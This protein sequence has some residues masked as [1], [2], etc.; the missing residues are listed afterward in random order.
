MNQTKY[1]DIVIIPILLI[2]LIL[3]TGLTF[4]NTSLQEA[5]AYPEPG[6]AQSIQEDSAYPA[7]EQTE[8]M[9]QN[10]YP[11][12][13]TTPTRTPNTNLSTT[14]EYTYSMY[15]PVVIK[16]APARFTVSGALSEDEVLQVVPNGLQYDPYNWNRLPNYDSS[17][18]M[19]RSCL[20]YREKTIH[21]NPI[22][23]EFSDYYQSNMVGH[24]C[25]DPIN[26]QVAQ[27]VNDPQCPHYDLSRP[28]L[29]VE[30]DSIPNTG[31]TLFR[32][33][34]HD[35]PSW[36]WL[37]GNEPDGITQDAIVHDIQIGNGVITNT[38]LIG[39]HA[40][41][42]EFF[43]QIYDIVDSEI[44]SAPK[45][46]FCQTTYAHNTNYCAAALDHLQSLGY[47]PEHIYALA[48]HQYLRDREFFDGVPYS[49][50]E[51]LDGETLPIPG[52]DR[53]VL[54]Y[55]IEERWIPY[56]QVFEAW[57]ES[58]GMGDKPLWL[59][60]F[61]SWAAWC[62]ETHNPPYLRPGIDHEGGLTCIDVG[63]PNVFYGRNNHEGLWG[64]QTKQ[65]EYLARTDNNWE[66]AWWF[67]SRVGGGCSVTT[68]IWNSDFDCTAPS[69]RPNNLSRAGETYYQA[70]DWV[71]NQR[72]PP[73]TVTT[74]TDDSDIMP[75]IPAPP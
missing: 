56:L 19:I 44:D 40:T 59:T 20:A 61:G 54:E 70:I 46:V 75:P 21:W 10:A 13:Y 41:Y 14:F 65:I 3:I 60:E 67:V 58:E 5:S 26:Q 53:T 72:N 12:P 55:A 62:F 51:L 25:W 16:P 1:A 69:P 30:H 57:A 48:V 47:G 28:C 50:G 32:E 2:L 52:D 6:Q 9:A 8:P 43:R 34:V 15:F 33:Y 39:D 64:L 74:I 4:V 35:N 7:P 31:E 68:W 36:I 71:I 73:I 63:K 45:L 17:V 27:I 66:V 11:A 23:V 42:A 29:D 18:Q 38:V 49:G 22:R 24:I 37:I